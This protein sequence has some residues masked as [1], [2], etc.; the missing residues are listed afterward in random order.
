VTAPRPFPWLYPYA[1]D[2]PRRNTIVLRP[3]VP[4][5]LVGTDASTPVLALIDSGAEHVL[6]APWLANDIGVDPDRAHDEMD[7]GIGGDVIRVRFVHCRLR[8]HPPGGDDEEYLEWESEL[9]LVS[10][11]KPTFPVLLG[12]RGFLDRFTVTM[13]RQ[14]QLTAVEDWDAFD[15]RFGVPIGPG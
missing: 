10:T 13:N 12:Q 5:T 6:A 11:W 14:G 1:E 8:L 3:V 15:A 4:L 9:G 7:L 2:G